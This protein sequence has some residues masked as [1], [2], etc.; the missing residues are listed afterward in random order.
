MLPNEDYELDMN[1]IWTSIPKNIAPL[2]VLVTYKWNHPSPSLQ[3]NTPLSIWNLWCFIVS[4]PQRNLISKGQFKLFT[5]KQQAWDYIL[6]ITSLKFKIY[7]KT[8]MC[9]YE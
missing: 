2:K 3:N 9:K 4:S 6:E 1:N 8:N 5:S 7:K